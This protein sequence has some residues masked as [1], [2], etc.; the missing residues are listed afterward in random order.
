MAA[1]TQTS[2]FFSLPTQLHFEIM[3]SLSV[4]DLEQLRATC[5][6]LQVTVSWKRIA[7]V[8]INQLSQYTDKQC[9]WCDRAIVIVQAS[10]NPSKVN[11]YRVAQLVSR[12]GSNPSFSEFS[13]IL[14][15]LKCD[16]QLEPHPRG[17]CL[18]DID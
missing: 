18:C 6:Q 11:H 4:Q 13:T 5:R 8:T 2:I 14:K 7:Q 3:N 17:V 16:E 15:A 10:Y 1:M 9:S 12:L